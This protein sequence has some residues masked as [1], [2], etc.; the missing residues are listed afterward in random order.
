MKF[1]NTSSDYGSISKFLHWSIA[2]LVFVQFALVYWVIYVLPEKSPKAGFLIGGLHK[3]LGIVV[4]ILA[5]LA[6]MWK[7]LNIKPG[8]PANM[9]AWEKIAAK[10]V[11]T[12]LYLCLIVMP[13]SG[14]IMSVAGGRPPN[15]FGLYQIPMFMAENKELS[16]F[17]FN[18]HR[19]TSFFLIGLILLHTLAALKHHFINRDGVLKRM[20]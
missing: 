13:L 9:P 15:F 3:P 16:N 11:H 5:L 14:V 7:L 6:I 4:L 17:F 20:L 12:L 8:F 2:I 19:F 18:L 10:G 1:K